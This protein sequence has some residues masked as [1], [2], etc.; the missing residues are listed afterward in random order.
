MLGYKATTKDA[1]G[2]VVDETEVFDGGRYFVMTVDEMIS[3][4]REGQ[5]IVIERAPKRELRKQDPRA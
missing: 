5:T 3:Q 4:L 1:K 2:N